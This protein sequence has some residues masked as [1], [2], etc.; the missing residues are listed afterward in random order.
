MTPHPL[1]LP[2]VASPCIKV[3]LLDT[4]NICVG[5]GRTLREIADWSR[6]TD[7]EQSAV[8]EQAA[9][10]RQALPERAAPADDIER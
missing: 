4:R 10:R 1:P 6:M 5:C 7:D 2:R 9:L 8:C 3:C